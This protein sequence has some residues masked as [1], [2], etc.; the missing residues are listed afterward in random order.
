MAKAPILRIAR[1][2]CRERP[3]S[4]LTLLAAPWNHT[5]EGWARRASRSVREFSVLSSAALPWVQV[6]SEL[7]TARSRENVQP[8]PPPL[9]V[10]FDWTHEARINPAPRV[11]KALGVP[12]DSPA[13][14]YRACL[15]AAC[16]SEV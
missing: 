9:L 16:L 14:M 10:A 8:S 4:V 2:M 12:A 11:E 3:G 13:C 6:C 1:E 7:E 5:A 15:T